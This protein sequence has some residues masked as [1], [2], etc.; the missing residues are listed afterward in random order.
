MTQVI[1]PE[2]KMDLEVSPL[3]SKTIYYTSSN[4][5][6]NNVSLGKSSEVI[7]QTQESQIETLIDSF[8]DNK[9]MNELEETKEEKKEEVKDEIQK[10]KKS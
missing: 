6:E 10:P 7:L 2:E 3:L 4:N 5:S 1:E 9:D 8:L